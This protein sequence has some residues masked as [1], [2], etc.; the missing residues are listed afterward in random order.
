MHAHDVCTHMHLNV[1]P[2][3]EQAVDPRTRLL[4]FKLVNAG[5]LEK[6]NGCISTGKESVVFHADGG[7]WVEPNPDPAHRPPLFIKERLFL[8]KTLL[9]QEQVCVCD[10]A[11][12][13]SWFQARWF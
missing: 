10:S 11:W 9:F 8:E 1:T 6:I 2:P 12:R 3:Q 4:M 5:V 13:G 7:R